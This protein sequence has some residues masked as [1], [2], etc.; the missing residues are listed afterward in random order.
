MIIKR[1]EK[2]RQ[3]PDCGASLVY[4][5]LSSVNESVELWQCAEQCYP[6]TFHLNADGSQATPPPFPGKK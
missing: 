1:S 5:G 6:H 3:C 2:E 4:R